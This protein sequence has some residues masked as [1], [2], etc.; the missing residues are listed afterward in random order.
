MRSKSIRSNV[1]SLEVA[2]FMKQFEPASELQPQGFLALTRNEVERTASPADTE[3]SGTGNGRSGSRRAQAGAVHPIN[4]DAS[5]S[6]L[7]SAALYHEASVP[8]RCASSPKSLW[9]QNSPD[10][11]ASHAG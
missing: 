2:E 11:L 1:L 3:A 4:L 9:S 5:Y 8:K 7:I 6:T 10:P